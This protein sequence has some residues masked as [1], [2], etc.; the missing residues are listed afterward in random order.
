MSVCSSVT[1]SLAGSLT[2]S[3]KMEPHEASSKA[4]ASADP[5]KTTKP[6]ERLEG[7][8]IPESLDRYY[9]LYVESQKN[10]STDISL[11][12]KAI[13]QCEHDGR[14]NEN[15]NQDELQKISD[16][17]KKIYVAWAGYYDNLFFAQLVNPSC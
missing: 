4:E 9:N 3:G 16:K 12:E 5:V 1:S 10:G 17:A 8:A 7:G 13:K 2:I 11:L 6:Q 14:K 15:F